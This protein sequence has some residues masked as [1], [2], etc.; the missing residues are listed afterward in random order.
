VIQVTFQVSQDGWVMEVVRV[1]DTLVGW[2]RQPSGEALG[3]VRLGQR[4]AVKYRSWW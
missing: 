2:N 3:M 4:A 1:G